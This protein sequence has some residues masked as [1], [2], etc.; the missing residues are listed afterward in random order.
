MDVDV[1]ELWLSGEGP[2]YC[3]LTWNNFDKEHY[4]VSSISFNLKRS[5]GRVPVWTSAPKV[6]LEDGSQI[7]V[8]D[9]SQGNQFLVPHGQHGQHLLEVTWEVSDRRKEGEDKTVKDNIKRLESC[10][11]VKVFFHKFFDTKHYLNLDSHDPPNWYRYWQTDGAI[12]KLYFVK[13][14]RESGFAYKAPSDIS[15]EGSFDVR[16]SCKTL[17]HDSL[18]CVESSPELDKFPPVYRIKQGCGLEYALGINAASKGKCMEH[19]ASGYIGPTVGDGDSAGLR[20]LASVIAHE[21]KHGEISMDLYGS[22]RNELNG[23]YYIGYRGR[24]Y[25]FDSIYELTNALVKAGYNGILSLWGAKRR[26]Y[27]AVVAAL[28]SR[29]YRHDFDGDGVSDISEHGSKYGA[30]GFS[31]T[32]P[33]TKNFA[34][35]YR[36][37]PT[38]ADKYATIGDNEVIAR[39]AETKGVPCVWECNDWAFPGCQ[40]FKGWSDYHG[41]Y[42][43]KWIGYSYKN[44]NS[45]YEGWTARVQMMNRRTKEDMSSKIQTTKS[46]ANSVIVLESAVVKAGYDENGEEEYPVGSSCHGTEVSLPI[47]SNSTGE[48]YV[49]SSVEAGVLRDGSGRVSSLGWSLILTNTTEEAM[50]VKLRCYLADSATNALAWAATNVEC[51]VGLTTVEMRFDAEDVFLWNTSRLLLYAATIES[52]AGD[53]VWNVSEQA[54]CAL[55]AAEYSAADLANDKG[56]IVPSSVAVIATS[57]GVMVTGAV[58]RVSGDAAQIYASLTDTNGLTVTS[59]MIDAPGVGTNDFSIFFSGDELYRLAKPLPYVVDSV[60]LAENDVTVHEVNAVGTVNAENARWFRPADLTIHA[61]AGSGAWSAPQ[62]GA[63]GL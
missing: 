18:E 47:F 7:E 54:P 4:Y 58:V 41:E 22:E 9:V 62:R 50:T 6:S 11:D 61:L 56:R 45:I 60:R 15:S 30:Y 34:G 5:G 26:Y 14:L 40:T 17:T 38:I 12:S 59:V 52:S 24:N 21:R 31:T 3:F 37:Y 1:G 2:Y 28:D 39:D 55:T 10:D 27:N 20:Q 53:M 29:C 48:V 43:K 8:F 57:E 25:R 46:F 36:K 49:V 35:I 33:D 63:D 32:N 13:F 51:A 19:G 42:A 16:G 44:W 23:F